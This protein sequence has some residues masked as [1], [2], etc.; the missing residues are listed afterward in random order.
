MSVERPLTE[1]K[2]RIPV[3]LVTGF[4]GSGKT[5][6]IN[7]ALRSPELSKTVVVVNE[8]GEVGLDHQLF[9]H[10]SDSVVVLENGCLCCTVRSDLIGT[11]NSLYHARQAGEIPDFD[12]VVIE[13]SGLAEPG[14]VLQAF[15]S[16]PTLDG[17]Y[18]VAGVLTLVDAVNWSGT[19]GAHEELLRQVALADQIRITKLDLVSGDRQNALVR[20]RLDLR[21][22]NPSA[23]IAE[24]DWSSAVV[25]KL[26]AS[27]GF[28]PA[29]P[30]ADPRPW[31][32]VRSYQND[33]R[34]H[35]ACGNDHD[36]QGHDHAR[37]VH[38]HDLQ[39]RGIENFVLMRETP[40][41]RGEAQFLLDGI[42][43]KSWRWT[44]AGQG[45]S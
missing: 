16:E 27:P 21:R 41:T 15:L 40:L 11:L 22:L 33:A 39:G 1:I 32:N 12:N 35:D 23:E 36:H 2:R 31:L 4:L 17:L 9:A 38:S 18:R 3:T 13:T 45:N 5:T 14:P 25:A 20:I 28:D 19:S 29:D 30:G 10:S 8:F 42:A 7:G 34:D 26:L 37:D 24:V 43:Q 6:L 44:S